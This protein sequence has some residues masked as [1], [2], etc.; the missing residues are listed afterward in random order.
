MPVKMR[1]HHE[2]TKDTR[3]REICSE[4]RALR[5]LRGKNCIPSY[6]K[7]RL[8]LGGDAFKKTFA[9]E[10]VQDAPSTYLAIFMSSLVSGLRWASMSRARRMP[11]WETRGRR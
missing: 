10:L 6:Y 3:V 4:L 2:G 9:L 1:F 7:P 8:A 5:V 11:S